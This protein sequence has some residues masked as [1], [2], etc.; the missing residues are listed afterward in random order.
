VITDSDGMLYDNGECTDVQLPSKLM[1][2]FGGILCLPDGVFFLGDRDYGSRL[3]I[4]NCYLQLLDLTKK[5]SKEGGPARSVYTITGTPG[6]GKT[7]F[8]LFILFY[9]RCI[10]Y[11]ATVICNDQNICYG[12]S[13][14]GNVQKGDVNQF[15]EALENP[16]NFYIADALMMKKYP[17]YKILLT[18]PK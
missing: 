13:P 4:R 14:E 8:G 11:K 12:F 9:I 17:A 15:E 6:I 16:E 2:N 1:D 5:D 3:L 10:Y 7:Y 18:S